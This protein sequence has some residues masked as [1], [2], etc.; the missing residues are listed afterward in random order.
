MPRIKP[1]QVSQAHQDARKSLEGIQRKLGMVP[2]LLKTIGRSPAA[3]AGYLNFNSSLQDALD[4][5]LREQLGLVVAGA[6]SCDYCASAHFALGQKAGV[7]ADEMAANLKG[8]SR[9]DQTRAALRFASALVAERG[10]VADDDIDD[11][12]AAGFTD[13]QILE[14][15][16]VVALNLFTNYVNHVAQTEI[17]FPIVQTV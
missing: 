1:V 17:D 11:V 5:Q 14:I 10:R 13:A 7:D 2:N 9:T 6:N 15:V 12:R 8:E 16:A 4:P 3:L